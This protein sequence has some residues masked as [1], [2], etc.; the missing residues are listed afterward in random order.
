MEIALS[1]LNYTATKWDIK[2]ALAKV[3]HQ[4]PFHYPE[5]H[6][7]RPINFE[8]ILNDGP[9]SLPNDGTAV[10]VLPDRAF[11]E[12]FFKWAICP[13]NRVRVCGRKVWLERQEK[14]PPNWRI[15]VLHKTPFLDP[16]LEAEREEI[17]DRVKRLD[18]ILDAIQF[19]VYYRR[20]DDLPSAH[21]RFSNEY[22]IR[23]A[24]TFSGRLCLDYTRRILRI[25]MGNSVT[26]D[27][28]THI[29]IDV[30]NIRKIGYG[31]N[32]A[33]RQYY[34]C[35]DLYNPARFEHYEMY[36]SYGKE[37]RDH[38]GFRERL[39]S[40]DGAHESIKQF[41]YQMRLVL[42][43][44]SSSALKELCQE[45]GITRPAKIQVDVQN[46]GF[47]RPETMEAVR[48]W[49]ENFDLPVAFQLEA[50]LY[51]G[52]ANTGDL[53]DLRA[54][55]EALYEEDRMFT[56]DV[57]RH[58]HEKLASKARG[59]TKH[60]NEGVVACFKS[61]V[62]ADR[63]GSLEDEDTDR[64]EDESTELRGNSSA[65]KCYHVVVTPTR[66]LLEGPF[67]TQSNRV[68]RK[69]CEY[70]D[71]FVRL[72]FREE[73]RMNF[74]WPDKHGRAPIKER[75]IDVL[76]NG[77]RI[78]GR[79]YRFLG[80][81]NS[82]L[83]EHTAWF[84][85]DFAHPDEGLVTPDRIRADL[86]DF[87]KVIHIPSKYAARIAQAFSG[88]DPSVRIT[89]DQW[90]RMEDLGT[91]PYEH[92]DGQ[93]TI[94]PGLRDK[95]W[96]EL[97]KAQP[98]KAKL[99]LK[100]SAI[101]MRFLGFKGIVVVDERLKG[102][103][104]RLRPSMDKFQARDESEAEIEIAK[105][106]VYPGTARLCRPLIMVL[107][108]LGVR[109]EAFLALQNQAMCTVVTA[110]D[111]VDSA[112]AL[113]RK[114]DL[115][116][117]FG[118]RWV[119]QHLGARG[120]GMP[121]EGAQRV[122]DDPFM[123]RLVRC[124][125]SHI[126]REIKHEAR[127]PIPNAHQLVGV[128]DEGPAWAKEEG[129]ENVFCLKKGEIFACIQQPD[130]DECEY[131]KGQ[132]SISRSPH[133]HPGDVQ[134]VKAIGKPPDGKLCFF[135]NL[136]NVVVLP[137]V[138]ERSLASCLAGG[139]VDGDEFLVI[140]DETLLPTHGVEPAEYVGVEPRKLDS[141]S[142]VDDICDFFLE[143]MQS[144]V[145]GLVADQHLKIADQ[146]RE[147]TFDESCM[148]LAQLCSQAV[149]YPKNG[150]P[151]DLENMPRPVI[152]IKP[153]WKKVTSRSSATQDW[154]A[155]RNPTQRLTLR[156]AQQGEDNDPRPGDYYESSR[157]LGE[158][159]RNFTF[160]MK[161]IVPPPSSYPNG[162]PEPPSG[163][164]P[165]S[166]SISRTLH[167]AIAHHLGQFA[168][169][170]KDVGALEPLFRYYAEELRYVCAT[171]ALS[172]RTDA[173]LCEEEVVVGT[174]LAKSADA[175]WRKER[176]YRMRVHAGQLVRHMKQVRL[177]APQGKDGDAEELVGALRRAWLAWDY[178]MRNRGV[179]GASSFSM[180]ALG[181]V[182]EMLE[183]L[184]K[185]YQD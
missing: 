1:D 167:G 6:K 68:V 39:T 56:A 49:I 111:T 160:D 2:R 158:L 108:D 182:L 26:E 60:R 104:M 156:Y 132:V 183:K 19:G 171:H 116:H 66:I 36:R 73:D 96:D 124:A 85:A 139:D 83:R 140:K 86:G 157:A 31:V 45:A 81:S 20:E 166:D 54:D 113:L 133:I 107:E 46:C 5:S 98:D 13:N 99:T 41:A 130:S 125:Q 63:A 176:M 147:G 115:G 135:R 58:F 168:N 122:V 16:M 138:G 172:D 175:R 163:E 25:E 71:Y 38:K 90:E 14:R 127:I 72:A 148:K 145:V 76:K 42:N 8:V 101:Q 151:V 50:L 48:E 152:H 178:G 91:H 118:L 7:A 37:K 29:A 126:L 35:L 164:R 150:V 69:Y 92:T 44:A 55:I 117:H 105:A 146:S 131:I 161:P 40:L 80:Y 177:R 184:D 21:R 78:A 89:R 70:R 179:F 100:P 165:L 67:D 94:S 159:F 141:P 43:E 114:H 4:P 154:L 32:Q 3:L 180:I 93:G 12:R 57:L 61:T 174:I 134:R 11:G 173:R 137:S 162:T 28:S 23:R 15:E 155:Q 149:D 82:G 65:I 112:V 97:V 52:L 51:N 53:W 9:G 144:D 74:K 59:E 110:I 62:E 181:V 84:M 10:L 121:K 47:F 17:L 136:R 106:F 30:S 120:M 33:A 170:D 22:E 88:T 129:A 95:I 142:T 87:H 77:V 103:C 79:L 24:D 169:A 119:L 64:Q 143:Y 153:D 123:L 27:T 34:V 102:V 128:A 18:I 75:F 109:K 185:M